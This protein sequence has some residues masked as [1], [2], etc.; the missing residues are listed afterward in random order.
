MKILR[1]RKIL[2][3]FKYITTYIY[4]KCTIFPSDPEIADIF[5]PCSSEKFSLYR[6]NDSKNVQ[7]DRSN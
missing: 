1:A 7:I 2:N 5:R 4:L 6:G 3:F